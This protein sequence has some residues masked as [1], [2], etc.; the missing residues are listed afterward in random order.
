[1]AT[2]NNPWTAPA[3]VYTV[4]SG[5][6]YALWTRATEADRVAVVGAFGSNSVVQ[7]VDMVNALAGD[8]IAQAWGGALKANSTLEALNLESNS[9]STG[10]ILALAEGL[11][12]N[13]TLKELK[14]ANQRANFTQQ[15]EEALAEALEANLSVTRLTIDLRSKRARDVLNK[16]LQR[17]QERRRSLRKQSMEPIEESAV[18]VG[19]RPGA[20]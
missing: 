9:I 18:M 11:R 19:R 12:E 10:G 6:N 15:A 17:N 2:P 8:A 3:V 7:R 20:V 5:Q 13:S 14:L 1:M 16:F 4:G